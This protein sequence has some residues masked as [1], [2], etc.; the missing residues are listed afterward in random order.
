[1]FWEIVPD[2]PSDPPEELTE[3]ERCPECGYDD[4]EELYYN[5]H[6]EIVGCDHCIRG[7]FWWEVDDQ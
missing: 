4:Y 5:I 7:V 1:M 3:D 6:N 2:R